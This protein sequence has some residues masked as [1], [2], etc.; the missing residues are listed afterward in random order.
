M[1]S[2]RLS[3]VEMDGGGREG[4][5][6]HETPSAAQ[7]ARHDIGVLR[8]LRN[9]KSSETKRARRDFVDADTRAATRKRNDSDSN[10]C[11]LGG[12]EQRR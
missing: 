11:S 8:R 6:R 9:K 1:S 2:A 3:I 10:C 4:T 7:A 5:V 12:T